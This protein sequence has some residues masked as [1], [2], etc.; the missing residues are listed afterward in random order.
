VVLFPIRVSV[1]PFLGDFVGFFWQFAPFA[2]VS[3]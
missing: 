2:K 3:P 1:E